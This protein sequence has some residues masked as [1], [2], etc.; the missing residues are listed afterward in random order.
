MVNYAV[1]ASDLT[2][3]ALVLIRGRLDFSRLTRPIDG[4][5]LDRKSVV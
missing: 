4:A 3:G 5:A 2:E 1:A